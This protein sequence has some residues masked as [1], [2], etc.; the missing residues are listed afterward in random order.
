VDTLN[1][2]ID[3][4]AYKVE[5]LC[6]GVWE[7][8][9]MVQKELSDP[10]ATY[11]KH[12]KLRNDNMMAEANRIWTSLHM[13][14]TNMLFAK[15]NY[16]NEMCTLGTFK[17]Q[18]EEKDF[19]KGFD[20]RESTNSKIAQQQLKTDKAETE[21]KTSIN[22]VNLVIDQLNTVYKTQLNRIQASDEGQINFVKFIFEKLSKVVD[23]TGKSFR[24]RSDEIADCAQMISNETDI[25]IFIEHHRSNNLMF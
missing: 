3:N 2:T 16:F 14:R 9:A 10:L 13:E 25:R 6:Q 17:R 8:A 5:L 20:P 15:E 1:T 11:A 24:D 4:I 22:N 12:Y 21:Y 18:M 23:T 7:Q 19:S